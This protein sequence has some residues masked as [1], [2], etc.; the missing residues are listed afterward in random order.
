MQIYI[1]FL[2][3]KLTHWNKKELGVPK[4]LFKNLDTGTIKSRTISF[5]GE[6]YHF[7]TTE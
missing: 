4:R 3:V 7:N 1:T 2:R 6:R 5:H